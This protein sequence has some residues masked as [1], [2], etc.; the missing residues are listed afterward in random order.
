MRAL[1]KLLRELVTQ[2]FGERAES[3]APVYRPKPVET[4]EVALDRREELRERL[5]SSPIAAIDPPFPSTNPAFEVASWSVPKPGHR[6]DQN[7]DAFAGEEKDGRLR[8][9]MSDGVTEES[10][11]SRGWARALC[12]GFLER[13]AGGMGSKWLNDRLQELA[14]AFAGKVEARVAAADTTKAYS[15]LAKPRAEMGSK[16]TLLGVEVGPIGS[17]RSAYWRAFAVGDTNLFVVRDG[18]MLRAWPLESSRD[19]DIRADV[20]STKSAER[21]QWRTDGK[22]WVREGDRLYLMTDALAQY[23]LRREEAGDP[24]WRSLEE[25]GGE[26]A[27]A[28]FVERAR[29]D[30][31]TGDDTTLQRIVISGRGG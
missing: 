7:Q 16:A 28:R 25:L 18:K 5:V 11:D 9:C 13:P 6:P 23:V 29:A 15:W 31:M 8:L 24:V 26:S 22:G 20:A 12:D 14:T 19:F 21:T 30:G 1:D 27:F 2:L 17:K 10:F 3:P 4:A